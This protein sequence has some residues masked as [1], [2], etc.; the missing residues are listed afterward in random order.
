MYQG[1]QDPY[2]GQYPQGQYPQGQQP[3]AEDE[4]E[5]AKAYRSI[6][7]FG[8]PCEQPCN[9][10]CNFHRHFQRAQGYAT[11]AP[12]ASPEE[13]Y[14]LE[15]CGIT[16]PVLVSLSVW[17]R[18]ALKILIVFFIIVAGLSF[19][20]AMLDLEKAR[21]NFMVKPMMLTYREWSDAQVRVN[22]PHGFVDYTFKV[23]A[24][25][26]RLTMGQADLVL[27][28][29]S[30]GIAALDVLAL[31]AVISALCNWDQF[32][33]SRRR[34]MLAWF[35]T[36]CAPFLASVIPARSFCDWGAAEG[37]IRLYHNEL[38]QLI[39]TDDRIYE[40]EDACRKANDDRAVTS[41][42]AE[43]TATFEKVCTV[44]GYLPDGRVRVPTGWNI[45][46]WK[47]VD[48]APAHDGCRQGR[49]MIAAKKPDDAIAYARQACS[50]L[51]KFIQE[52]HDRSNGG[53]NEEVVNLVVDR[54]AAISESLI[55]LMLALFH[56][57]TMFP[58][59]LS[60][61]PGLLRGSVRMK[62][63]A[64]RSLIPGMLVVILPWMSA[65]LAWCMYSIA[66]QVVGNIY[67]L[68]ALMLSAFSLCSARMLTAQ[69]AN[70]TRASR[71]WISSAPFIL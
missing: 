18:S 47:K 67:L 44:I 34:L 50:I 54:G 20:A 62:M 66:V 48:F 63:L 31:C 42:I 28:Y 46:K 14:H 40:L 37:V 41:G 30:L 64:P 35:L 59:A 58:A 43:A 16:R 60:L 65:P 1:Y 13:Q 21:D 57:K 38:N 11:S 27:A 10:I 12:I 25:A 5:S 32:H 52:F 49:S 29:G 56:V 15:L 22:A 69:A 3:P 23:F 71:T 33:K 6:G 61:A 26:E 36:V 39:G 9:D 4:E 7:A 53:I 17:R 2:Y 45:F 55:S 19:S 8:G 24:E 68:L 51:D 70:W